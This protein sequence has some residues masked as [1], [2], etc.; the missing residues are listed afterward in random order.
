[1]RRE[2]EGKKIGDKEGGRSGYR[3]ERGE[4]VIEER[5]IERMTP[6]QMRYTRRLK[7]I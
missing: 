6:K 3:D 1:M 4:R 2:R 5:V 7:E